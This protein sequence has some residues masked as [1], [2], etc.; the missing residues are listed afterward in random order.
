M[1]VVSGGALARRR[2]LLQFDNGES[3][4][5]S[6]ASGLPDMQAVSLKELSIT[7]MTPAVGHYSFRGDMQELSA[8]MVLEYGVHYD[9]GKRM[10]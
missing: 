10:L 9:P 8:G 5:I 1:D 7:Y 6:G 2:S 4:T 3:F